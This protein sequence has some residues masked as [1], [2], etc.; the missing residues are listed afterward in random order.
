[1]SKVTYKFRN[2]DEGQ[3]AG[4]II[5]KEGLTLDKE[6]PELDK[7]STEPNGLLVKSVAGKVKEDKPKDETPVVPPQETT[8]VVPPQEPTTPAEP[9]AP[10]ASAQ[11]SLE[12][13]ESDIVNVQETDVVPEGAT[14][15]DEV[16]IVDEATTTPVEESKEEVP[17]AP[18]K[19]G[20]RNK[21]K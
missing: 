11:T 18:T 4:L 12:V 21:N 7:L 5:R 14:V 15:V 3:A 13:K 19:G 8:P 17:A 9:T 1:M 20:R 6:N 16:K 2:G 10:E